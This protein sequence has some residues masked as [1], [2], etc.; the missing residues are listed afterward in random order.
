MKVIYFDTETT[1]LNFRYDRIIELAM[2]TVEDGV[3]KDPYDEFINIGV[4]LPPKITQITGIT[5]EMLITKGVGE[6][7]VAEDLKN[8][9]PPGTLMIAHNCQFDLSF[10]YNLLKRHYPDEADEIVSNLNWIDTVTVLKDRKEFPH[11]LI[12]AVKHYEI[13]EVNFHR[14]IDDTK[15]L[16]DVTQEMKKERNDLKEYINIFGYNPKW[17]VSGYRFPFITYKRQYFTKRMVDQEN[18][19]PRK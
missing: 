8:R 3:I 16:Y 7:T 11:K 15:A 12:D 2:L 19:L 13:E 5:D 10:V 6:A 17:G 1:G 9:L 4:D 18:I 14:A